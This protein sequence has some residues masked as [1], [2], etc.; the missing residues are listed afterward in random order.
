MLALAASCGSSNGDTSAILGVNGVRVP[1]PQLVKAMAGLCTARD[2]AAT[3]PDS[4]KA[5]FFDDS[6]QALHDIA[7]ALERTDRNASAT[8]LIAKQRVEADLNAG[9]STTLV[10]DLDQLATVT[11]DSLDRLHIRAASCPASP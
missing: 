11:H 7:A 2:Q 5:T 8:L 1:A 3:T 4:A 9:Q 6:H 10:A